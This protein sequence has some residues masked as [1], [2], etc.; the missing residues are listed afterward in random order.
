MFNS[1]GG[2]SGLFN[3]FNPGAQQQQQQQAL[4]QQQQIN[5]LNSNY[6][7]QLATIQQALEEEKQRRASESSALQLIRAE[8]YSMIRSFIDL[9]EYRLMF[10][11]GEPQQFNEYAPTQERFFADP[12]YQFQQ[13]EG[14]RNLLRNHA[15]QGLVHSGRSV[16]DTLQF[17]QDL[18]NQAYGQWYDRQ[19][20]MYNNYINRIA[21]I[22]GLGPSVNGAQNAF[23]TGVNQANLSTGTG[24]NLASSFLGQGQAGLGAFLNTGAAKANAIMQAAEIQGQVESAKYKADAE[25]DAAQSQANAGLAK[26]A[27]SAATSLIGGFIG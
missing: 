27:I 14:I 20:N 13:D 18:A 16:R 21:A 5:Q 11:S 10:S 25:R 17:S 24:T 8:P 2:L 23:N 1:G 12:G 26:G 22:A 9:P 19:N 3:L 6:Q 15:A 4:L 7:D